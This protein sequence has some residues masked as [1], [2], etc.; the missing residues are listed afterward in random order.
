M[1]PQTDVDHAVLYV[2]MVRCSVVSRQNRI[3]IPHRKHRFWYQSINCKT[4]PRIGI[5]SGHNLLVTNFRLNLKKLE[6]RS[7]V[8]R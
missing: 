4:Y 8:R 2:V 3:Q 7:K 6:K 5:D 1:I